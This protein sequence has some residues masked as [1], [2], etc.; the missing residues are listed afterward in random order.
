MIEPEGSVTNTRGDAVVSDAQARK[1]ALMVA[2]VLLAVAAW[3][4]YRG[5][6]IVVIIFGSAG[7]LLFVVGVL[8]PSAARI[9]HNAWMRFAVALGRFNSRVLL[10][11]MYYLAITPYGFISRL[12]G[13][14]PLRRRGASRESYWI[15]RKRTRQAREQFE[16]LF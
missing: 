14:D 4:L 3:N 13:R 10:T 7:A 8:F 16:R 15:A 5:R 1:T 9:F 11:L 12:A 6:S 2:S